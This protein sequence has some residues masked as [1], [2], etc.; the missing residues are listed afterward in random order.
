L[1]ALAGEKLALLAAAGQHGLAVFEAAVYFL[2]P[3]PP[4]VDLV[5]AVVAPPDLRLRRLVERS[6]GPMTMDQARARIEAQADLEKYW[7]RADEI[8]INDGTVEELKT[9]TLRLVPPAGPGSET[10]P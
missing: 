6:A 9:K 4:A 5:V 2:L 7:S 1:A 3:S 10:Q 8:I